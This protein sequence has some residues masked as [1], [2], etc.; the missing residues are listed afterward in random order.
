MALTSA[1]ISSVLQVLLFAAVPFVFYLVGK[2][3]VRGFLG[4]L[5]L[6]R[7]TARA[8]L[9]ATLLIVVSAPLPILLYVLP[10]FREVSLAPGTTG[11]DFSQ[12]NLSVT[13]VAVVLVRAFLQSGLAEEIVFRGFIAKRLI[14][15]LGF[16]WGNI[17]Q[18]LVFALPH[19][20]IFAVPG[21]PQASVFGVVI[22]LCAAT[23][24]G[25]IFGYLNERV[26]GGSIAP[27]W[28]CHGGANAIAYSAAVFS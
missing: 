13:T 28:W 15:W 17:L 1:A 10:A 27:S 21:G 8:M 9:W 5:G 6:R 24:V 7:T 14:R 3:R 20:A 11:G 23:A 25:W 12:M 2:R 26:G 22:V 18:A 16:R 4:W 19:L